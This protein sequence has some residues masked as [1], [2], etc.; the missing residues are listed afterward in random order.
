MRITDRIRRI[1]RCTIT[2]ATKF[3]EGGVI[4]EG[5]LNR[6]TKI[7][8]KMPGIPSVICSCGKF[9]VITQVNL[10]DAS[11]FCPVCRCAL[12]LSIAALPPD[13]SHL[14]IERR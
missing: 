3:S 2:R 13:L 9:M 4:S 6:C 8:R 10:G 7:Y 11:Y 12:T 1:F 5:E 14:K